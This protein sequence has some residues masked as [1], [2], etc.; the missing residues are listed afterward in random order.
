MEP[1]FDESRIL[2]ASDQCLIINKL[3]GE[4]VEGAE[5]GMGDLPRLLAEKYGEFRKGK[6]KAMLPTAVHRLDVPV[7]GCV[8]FARTPKALSFLNTVFSDGRAEKY[9]WAAVELPPPSLSLPETG[10]LIHW[11]ETDTKRNKSTALEEEGP[12][13]KKGILR[14]RIKGMGKRYMFLEIELVTGRHHQIRAQLAALGLHVK[15]DL[16]Y[17]AKRSEKA[18]GI[19]LHARSIYFPDPTEKGAFVAVSAAPPVQDRL[20][21]DFE[22]S[23]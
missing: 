22:K 19:R 1:I 15:G 18:G 7:S 4:A 13:R 16:K 8:L 9:Y 12:N 21:Q 17:G 6:G 14:Y 3:P 2:Y 11:I 23:L 10:E 20:W 5:P